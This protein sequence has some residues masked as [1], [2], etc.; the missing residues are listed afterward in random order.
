[1]TNIYIEK[2]ASAAVESGTLAKYLL[3][4]VAVPG[5][6]IFAADLGAHAAAEKVLHNKADLKKVA[7]TLLEK[8]K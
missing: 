3:H 7:T 6:T 4:N 5:A 2:I 1:M 8:S